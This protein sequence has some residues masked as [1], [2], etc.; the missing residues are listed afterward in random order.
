[1]YTGSYELTCHVN[2]APVQ[3]AYNRLFTRQGLER[4]TLRAFVYTIVV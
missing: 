1:M 2:Y 3:D 4:N